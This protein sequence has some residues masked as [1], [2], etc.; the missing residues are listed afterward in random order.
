MV[1]LY[2]RSCIKTM[3]KI[4]ELA[5]SLENEYLS[6]Y[7]YGV[8]IRLIDKVAHKI[9]MN[10][11]NVQRKVSDIMGGK[12]LDLD[13]VKNPTAT[14]LYTDPIHVSEATTIKAITGLAAG[15]YYV[16]VKVNKNYAASEETAIV[17]AAGKDE[18]ISATITYA[19]NIP[20]EKKET[21][22]KN[23]N[24]DKGDVDGSCS[25]RRRNKG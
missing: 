11:K 4:N 7:S 18:D 13:I 14:K 12:V 19:E 15:T 8:I 3:K 9:T 23:T 20:V 25:D 22:I 21:T 6:A 2:N 5:L 10:R 17:I 1:Q 16:R 24:T